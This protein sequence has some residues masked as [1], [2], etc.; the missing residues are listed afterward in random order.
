[1]LKTTK[2]THFRRHSYRRRIDFPSR[3]RLQGCVGATPLLTLLLKQLLLASSLAARSLFTS[4]SKGG[5]TDDDV[6]T[7]FSKYHDRN[8]PPRP[9]DN[10]DADTETVFIDTGGGAEGGAGGR[11]V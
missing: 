3:A 4:S 10:N 8:D 1:M 9:S 7:S 5:N 6:K 2:R 11:G